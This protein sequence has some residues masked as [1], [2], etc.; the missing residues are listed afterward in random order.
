[1]SQ[2]A[3]EFVQL[4]TDRAKSQVKVQTVWVTVKEVDWNDKTMT[5]TGIVD[6]LDFN[7][8][9]LGLG[10]VYVKPKKDTKCLVGMIENKDAAAF[11]IH[12][13]EVEELSVKVDKMLVDCTDIVFNDGNN[14]GLVKVEPLTQRL[15]AIEQKVNEMLST[16]QG[17]SIELAPSGTYPFAPIFSPITSL[18]QTAQN[19]IE[20]TDIKH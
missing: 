3:T 9:L 20:N 18:Q 5:A 6:G 2:E 15:N 10:S 1:M 12:A 17:V 19:D 8:V 13:E 14:H 7:E 4:L 11:L 16:L